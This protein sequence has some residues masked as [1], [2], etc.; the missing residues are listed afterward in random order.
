MIYNYTVGV[1]IDSLRDAVKDAVAIMKEADGSV[2]S[3]KFKM[4]PPF[5]DILRKMSKVNLYNYVPLVV[6]RRPNVLLRKV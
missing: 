4:V 5:K 3:K 6:H 1:D 2:R